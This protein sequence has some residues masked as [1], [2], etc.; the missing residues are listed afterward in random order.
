M[1]LPPG[2][3]GANAVITLRMI[4]NVISEH[5]SPSSVPFMIS[6]LYMT[7]V[8]ETCASL[9]TSSQYTGDKSE[10]SALLHRFKTRVSS[11]LQSKLPVEKWIG[12]ALAKAAMESSFECLASNGEV[13]VRLMVP[14]LTKPEPS[15]TIN[16]AIATLTRVFTV[17]T[18]DK[19]TLIRQIVSPNLPVTIGHILNILKPVN[20]SVSDAMPSED[21][22]AT[23]LEALKDLLCH[24]PVT[25][26]PFTQRA[27]EI[28]LSV[29][30]PQRGLSKL[31]RLAG[32]LFVSLHLSGTAPRSGTSGITANEGGGSS[33]GNRATAV[34]EGWTR[35]VKAVISEIDELLDVILRCMDEGHRIGRNRSTEVSG[36]SN[37]G[38]SEWK[39]ISKG[40]D[41]A[42]MLLRLLSRFLCHPTSSQ[43]AVPVGQ[44]VGLTGRL[45]GLSCEA[46]ENNT[47]IERPERETV[48]VRLSGLKCC[49]LNLL[50]STIE[51]LGRIFAPLVNL[52]IEQLAFAYSEHRSDTGIRTAVYTLLTALLNLFGPALDKQTV[53]S[54]HPILSSLYTDLVLNADE[55]KTTLPAKPV[56]KR[57]N[58]NTGKQKEIH[59]DSLLS[60]SSR[61]NSRPMWLRGL[62]SAAEELLVAVLEKLPPNYVR[63][64]TRRLLDRAAVFTANEKAMM[65]SVLFPA[66]SPDGNLRGRS[67]LPHLVGVSRGNLAVEGIVRPRL[68]VLWVGRRR[69]DGVE[70]EEGEGKDEEVEDEEEEEEAAVVHK[71]NAVQSSSIIEKPTAKR[72]VSDDQ[73]TAPSPKRRKSHTPIPPSASPRTLEP[74]SVPQPTQAISTA[75]TALDYTF[76]KT[77][78]Q[79]VPEAQPQPT[80]P[81]PTTTTATATP[82]FASAI[83]T[84]QHIEAIRENARLEAVDS[85]DEMI[86]PEIDMGE[87]SDD[88]DDESEEI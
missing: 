87:S 50:S 67:I 47:A 13:W 5:T 9:S 75:H 27:Q 60:S 52:V 32:D 56:G 70:E 71:I 68:P 73:D 84:T 53:A 25:F 80:T 58:R 34:A 78:Q 31:G 86:I 48:I 35:A 88:D 11:L 61:P 44:F 14:I 49:A 39:G 2:V 36:V 26:R 24:N 23:A 38:L 29:L 54:V 16:Y 76:I 21:T 22:L 45:T 4:N 55:P 20:S 69:A 62:I 65:A 74:D 1:P 51:R 3:N 28:V 42:E 12:I 8:L 40:F 46:A 10:G 72:S 7:P 77:T 6:Q 18:V 15:P 83:T 79:T 43:V 59:A 64:Q 33:S 81:T 57:G 17:L 41:R 37:I 66:T 85:D 63:P 82:L 19:P 30:S